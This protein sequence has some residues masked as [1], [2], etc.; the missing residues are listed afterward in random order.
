MAFESV[1]DD[2]IRELLE[3]RKRV[4]N[5]GARA[6]LKG[7]SEQFN[8]TVKSES[9][10]DYVFTLYT[11]QNLREGMEDDFSCGL[12]WTAPNG[13]V[14]TLVRYNGSSHVHPNPIEGTRLEYVCHVHKAT[15]RYVRANRKPDTY[16]TESD[17]YRTLKG[18]L[19]CLVSDCNVKGLS[20]TADEPS[21]FEK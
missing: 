7:V 2:K 21:L 8:Y 4:T 13:E 1:T 10:A 11:R 15:E 14:L 19:H 9:D 5:P 12:S 18:A 17:Q 6:K 3:M 16:A 20:T